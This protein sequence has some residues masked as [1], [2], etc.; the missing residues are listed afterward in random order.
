MVSVEKAL[1]A[2]F[3]KVGHRVSDDGTQMMLNE[4]ELLRLG[5]ASSVAASLG[6]R[7]VMAKTAVQRTRQRNMQSFIT[8]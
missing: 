8:E 7:L 6:G 4:K 3:E 5:N 1:A 2:G